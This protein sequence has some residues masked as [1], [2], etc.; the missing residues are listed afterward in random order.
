MKT[1]I[2][3]DTKTGAS[4][5]CADLLAQ[6]LDAEI[7]DL[8][9]A[10]PDINDYETVVIGGGIYGGRFSPRLRKFIK[11]NEY[12][13]HTKQFAFFVC[14]AGEND[15][16]KKLPASIPQDL[17]DKAV[18]VECFGYCVDVK[19]TQGFMTKLI[20]KIMKKAFESEGKPLYGIKE[21]KIEL[22]AQKLTAEERQ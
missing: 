1:I 7:A 17:L 20:A 4:Q 21:D 6:K 13:L 14:C 10:Q 11:N 18:A 19:N 15:Y 9:T 3:F 5:I 16:A 8:R 22:F 2:I 12:A